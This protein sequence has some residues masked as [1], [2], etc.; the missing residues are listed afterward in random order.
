MSERVGRFLVLFI[1]VAV[2]CFSISALSTP[3]AYAGSCGNSDGSCSG[4]DPVATGCSDNTTHVATTGWADQTGNGKVDFIN[5][6][7]SN[8]SGCR[9]NWPQSI[10]YFD[11]G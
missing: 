2:A 5:D 11:S 7:W 8:D 10:V 4:A 6:V 3:H 9:T 1:F